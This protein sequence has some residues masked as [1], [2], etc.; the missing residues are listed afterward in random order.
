MTNHLSDILD[1]LRKQL[2]SIYGTKWVKMILYGSQAR[3]DAQPGS[4]I[5][6]LIVLKGEVH[7]SEEVSR[8][9]PITAALS[10]QYNVVISC[11]FISEDKVQG[12]DNPFLLNIQREGV[13]V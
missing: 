5:D 6:V 1:N 10:L 3:G 13:T 2:Y 9:V 7:P 4:D 11:T 8:T 12:R